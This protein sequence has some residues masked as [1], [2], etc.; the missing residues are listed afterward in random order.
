MTFSKEELDSNL[1]AERARKHMQQEE[2]SQATGISTAAIT[3]YENG[4]YVP[5]ADKIYSLA[6]ALDTTPNV[7]LGF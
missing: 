2:L 4:V 7:L 3:A 5:G 1:R 6:K